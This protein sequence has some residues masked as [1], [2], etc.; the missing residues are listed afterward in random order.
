M[1]GNKR[2][3]AGRP[4]LAASLGRHRRAE[5]ARPAWGATALGLA[6][7]APGRV[8]AARAARVQWQAWAELA[9]RRVQVPR[10]A[11]P[12]EPRAP[13]APRAPPE[14]VQAAPARVTAT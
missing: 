9:Q 2:R 12:V 11:Q 10:A 5:A 8:P 7:A 13:R 14:R 6:S 3:P 4:A 1:R